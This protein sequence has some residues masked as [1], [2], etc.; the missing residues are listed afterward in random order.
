VV[1]VL[2]HEQRRLR[3]APTHAPSGA[4]SFYGGESPPQSLQYKPTPSHMGRHARGG[5]APA[6]EVSQLQR[7]N[8]ELKME[9]LRLKMRMR[10][11]PAPVPPTGAAPPPP[12]RQPQPKKSGGGGGFMNNVSKKLG[13]LNPFVRHDAMGV[14]K[15]R[16][17]PHKNRRH[18][19]EW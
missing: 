13:K 5:A 15:V 14:P 12:G 1:Q 4:S 2:Y 9:L 18:S 3:E 6:D 11:P 17:K 19:I 7:E 8:D 10:D 16:T